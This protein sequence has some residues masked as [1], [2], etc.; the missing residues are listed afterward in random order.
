MAQV[1]AEAVLVQLLVGVLVP[2]AAGVGGDLVSQNDGAVTG[3][4][5]LQLE[6]HQADARGQEELLEQVV[7]LEGQADDGVD[8]L[9]GGQL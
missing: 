4:A 1:P 8:L 9:S 3:P 6:V 2:Q 7:D 5:E